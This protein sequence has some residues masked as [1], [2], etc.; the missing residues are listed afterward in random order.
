[1]NWQ[2]KNLE[3]LNTFAGLVKNISQESN[4]SEAKEKKQG[5]SLD[6]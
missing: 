4:F 6:Y 2:L 5:S 3:K 1:M